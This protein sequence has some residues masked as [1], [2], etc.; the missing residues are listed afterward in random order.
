[1]N[2]NKLTNNKINTLYERVLR[3]IYFDNSSNFQELRYKDNW[4]YTK[5]LNIVLENGTFIF[6]SFFF[7]K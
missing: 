5:Y 2:C 4:T 3:L 7:C 1:M 6:F